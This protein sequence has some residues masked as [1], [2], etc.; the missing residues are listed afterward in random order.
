MG[1]RKKRRGSQDPVRYTPVLDLQFARDLA[2]WEATDPRIAARVMRIVQETLASPSEGIGKPEPLRE[3]L[4]GYWSRRLTRE[5]RILY[6]VHG[7][8]V[9][10]L[11][12]RG[13]Y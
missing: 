6:R 8:T 2:Y 1:S 12:A 10:F 3:N 7:T 11:S 5:H 9:D 13:H 4:S